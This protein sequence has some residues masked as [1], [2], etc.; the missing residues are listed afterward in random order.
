MLRENRQKAPG[1]EFSHA[2]VS[3]TSVEQAIGVLL[4]VHGISPSA[5]FEVLREVAQRTDI[6]V[7]SVAETLTAWALG[8]PLPEPVGHELTAAVQRRTR[9]DTTDRPG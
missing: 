1:E 8:R 6:Q 5:G 3:H 9:G 7:H 4:A 2:L